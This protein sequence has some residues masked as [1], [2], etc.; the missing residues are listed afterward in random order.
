MKALIN[1]DI[2]RPVEIVDGDGLEF[3]ASGEIDNNDRGF[4]PD[5]E[6]FVQ[7]ELDE[8]TFSA[9]DSG[10]DYLLFFTDSDQADVE[11]IDV[12]G[13]SSLAILEDLALT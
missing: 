13:V 1:N 5:R 7:G 6:Y 11:N 10:D 4:Q 12:T 2:S 9:D 8:G 3:K